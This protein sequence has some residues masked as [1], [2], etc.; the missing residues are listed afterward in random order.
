[1][2]HYLRAIDWIRRLTPAQAA[3]RLSATIYMNTGFAEG[4]AGQYDHAIADQAAAGVILSAWL[5]VDPNNTYPIYQLTSV[6]RASGIVEGYRKNAAAAVEDFHKAAEPHRALIRHDPTNTTYRYQRAEA[7]IRGGNWRAALHL[8]AE[9][10]A[11]SA[12]GLQVVED[13]A[14]RPKARL[15]HVFVGCRWLAETE[16]V[17]LRKPARAAESCRKAMELTHGEDPEAFSGLATA[18]DLMGGRRGAALPVEKD[19]T[20]I[21][22]PVPG[23]PPSH[24]SKDLEAAPGRLRR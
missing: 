24:Q 10:R 9:A 6:Y 3:R 13:L 15:S 22:P 20:F 1:M 2:D 18:L 5:A 11:Q 12:E 14:A 17:E 8:Q 23:Q 4:Q 21:P 16:V 7:L 19:L